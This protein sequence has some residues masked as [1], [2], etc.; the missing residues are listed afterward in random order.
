MVY[1]FEWNRALLTTALI[2]GVDVSVPAF[3]AGTETSTPLINAVVNNAVHSS[4]DDTLNIH[5]DTN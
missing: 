2:S 4:E 3:N 5:R 1:Q